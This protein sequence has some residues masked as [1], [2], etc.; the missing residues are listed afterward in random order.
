MGDVNYD[1][2]W[3]AGYFDAFGIQEWER[4]VAEPIDEVAL[5]IHTHYL[6]EFVQPGAR[7]LEVGAGAGRFTQV[8]AGLGAQIVVAD[9]SPGQLALNQK[10]AHELGFAGAVEAW[11]ELDICDMSCFAEAAFDCVVAYG[12]PLSYVLDKRATAVAECVR[13]LKPGGLL[14]AG[15]ISMWGAAHQKLRGV[16]ALVPED[17]QQITASGDVLP[18]S[19]PQA[20][21]FMHMYR[22]AEFQHLL[23]AAGLE[24]VIMSASQCLSLGWEELVAGIR[25]DEARWQELLRME[26]AACVDDGAYG[27]GPHMIAVAQKEK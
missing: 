4:M 26:L 15:V 9:I 24:I 18:G 22:P 13:V 8:L 23:E 11:Q 25:Q 2:G 5:H 14:L 7:V 27:L 3:V 21:H 20:R 19:F 6:Q 10:Y 1:P 16:M 17:N 12:G